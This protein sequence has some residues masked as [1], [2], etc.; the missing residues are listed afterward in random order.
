MN[1]I[2]LIL[3]SRLNGIIDRCYN[4]NSKSYKTYGGAGVTVCEEW[5]NYPQS[6][7]DWSIANGFKQDLVIDK[8]ILCDE[9]GVSPKVY[10]PKTCQWITLSENSKYTNK[11]KKSEKVIQYSVK[12]EYIGT[13][14][15]AQEAGDALGIAPS[16]INRVCNNKR[17]LAG[18]FQWKYENNDDSIKIYDPNGY[19]YSKKVVKIHPKTFKELEVFN[20][21]K[22]A[23]ASL[24][25]KDSS[26]ISAVCKGTLLPSGKP[27]KTAY[28]YSWKYL[29]C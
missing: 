17:K 10:S 11:H 22:A 8:D 4:P 3:R 14:S 24:G 25:K 5:L 23:A 7:I 9:L 26:V 12:G 19:R 21:V 18:G 2:E 28:G 1:K 13:Y 15:S 29:T 27:R 6:F 16:N 20:S